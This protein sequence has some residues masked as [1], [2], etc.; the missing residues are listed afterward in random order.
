MPTVPT[1]EVLAL[2]DAHYEAFYKAKPFADKTSHTVPCDTKSWSQVLVSLLT[3]LNGRERKKGSDLVDGSDVKGANCW[4]AIDTPRFNGSIPAGRVSKTSKKVEAVA[5]LD[6][7]PFIFF[8]LW[9]EDGD[10]KPRCRIWCVRAQHDNAFRSICKEWYRQK[11]AGKI[12]SGNFQLHPPRFRDD[13]IF[14]NKCGSLEYPLLFSA[15]RKA[16]GFEKLHYDSGVLQHGEC[17]KA[18]SKKT[19]RKK[20]RGASRAK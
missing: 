10:G 17:K 13:N 20:K 14:D 8:V 4:S 19:R 2:L 12:K 7:M 11:T 16:N 15:V 3:G 5:A 18:K 9:D 6:D 1:N